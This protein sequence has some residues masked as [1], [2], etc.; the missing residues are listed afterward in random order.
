[1]TDKETASQLTRAL[2]KRQISFDKFVEE[3]PEDENDKDIFD[4]FDLIEHEPGKTGIF[5]V[6]V[7]RHKN[8]MDFVYDLIYK[9]DPVPDLIGGAKTLFYTD[10]DSRHEK[11]DKT[12]HFIGG[13]QVND[14]SC[15][16]ICEYDNESGYYLFGCDSDWSTIT[17]TFHDKIEDAKE[18]AESEYKNTIETWRQK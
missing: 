16:A 2:L 15:L 7:S 13:Q 17:D 14:I 4:L 1:M 12:K 6:S 3:F 9:L 10:I 8:H 5:G 18:Q 11:T